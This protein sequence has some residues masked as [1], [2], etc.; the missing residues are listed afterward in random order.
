LEMIFRLSLSNSSH[1]SIACYPPPIDS[2]ET[3]D[4]K[5]QL[6][7]WLPRVVVDP[8]IIVLDQL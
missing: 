1:K 8:K 4:S 3:R 2:Y 6:P 7:Q 5:H